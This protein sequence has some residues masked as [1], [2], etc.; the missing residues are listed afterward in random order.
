[1]PVAVGDRSVRNFALILRAGPRVRGRAA[2]E[3][4]AATPTP[5]Q[6][7]SVGVVL[8]RT[9]GQQT[10]A[11][12]PGRFTDDGQFA[13]SSL[14]PARYLVRVTDPPAGWT[15]KGA[16]YQGR[17]I[18]ETALDVVDDV[19]NVVLTFTDRPGKI[20][21]TVEGTQ[22]GRS[23]IVILFPAD[24]STWT[25]YGRNSR[26]ISST[27]PSATGA[28]ALAAAP[29]G[30][31]FLVAIPDEESANWQNPAVLAK[32]AGVAERIQIRDGQSTSRVLRVRHLQ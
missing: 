14:W 10:N 12:L 8:E 16:T 27:A 7:R 13:T 31:Y 9:N 5:A 1:V 32:L 23:T 24:A 29:A 15:F 18:S 2:F 28:F 11:I 17:D 19:E 3:G 20:E 6:W 30:E 4:S 22:P 25:G 26:R 21:G